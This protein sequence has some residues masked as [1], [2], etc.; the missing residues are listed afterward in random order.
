MKKLTLT[1]FVLSLLA[2]PADAASFDLRFDR[3]G[4]A[5]GLLP[6]A[7]QRSV[8]EVVALIKRGDNDGAL[9]RLNE[10]NKGNPDNSSLRVLTGYALLQI[11]NVLGALEQAD[12]A[13]E[14]SNGNSYKCWFYSK[15]ALL[16]GKPD[17]CKREL[18]HV[19]KVG[20]MP[21]EAKALE[22]ELKKKKG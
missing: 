21:A 9:K 11:G 20:D 16:S 8:D 17:L 4:E 7:D 6:E 2:L 13:H 19:K 22:Q 3:L 18:N 15:I 5:L 10:L 1:I 12:K 14:A